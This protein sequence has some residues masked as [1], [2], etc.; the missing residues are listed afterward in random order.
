MHDVN[1]F[2]ISS[3]SD[4][5]GCVQFLQL[6]VVFFLNVYDSRLDIIFFRLHFFGSELLDYLILNTRCVA[7]SF[8]SPCPSGHAVYV[9]CRA[10]VFIHL[11]LIGCI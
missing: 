7:Q 9:I 4:G 3:E 2:R 6:I 8:F 10:P 1:Y 5:Y 11:F